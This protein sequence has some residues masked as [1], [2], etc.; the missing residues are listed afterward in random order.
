MSANPFIPPEPTPSRL[1]ERLNAAGSLI[2]CGFLIA[3]IACLAKAFG[4]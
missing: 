3:V 4:A 1:A 2:G